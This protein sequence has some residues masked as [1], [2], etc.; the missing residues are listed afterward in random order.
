MKK[1]IL[2]ISLITLSLT[3]N[4][5]II[6]NNLLDGYKTGDKLEKSAYIE[7][8]AMIQENTWCAAY[9]KDPKA[10]TT[11]S[12]IIGKELSYPEYQEGGPSIQFGFEDGI[13]GTR[14]SVYSMTSSGKTYRQGSYYLA[15]L[16]N[17]S[18]LGTKKTSEF[19][20]LIANHV[21]GSA[22]G[23]IY[24]HRNENGKLKFTVGLGKNRTEAPNEYD[25]KKTHLLVLKVDYTNNRVEL[26]VNPSL[27][28]EEAQS[29]AMAK[30]EEGALKAGLKAIS[31]RNN[32]TYQGNIGNIRFAGRWTDITTK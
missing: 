7:P 27:K 2:I 21:G 31:I 5:Q 25:F 22:R 18:K 23:N 30:G 26:F 8:K 3:G 16:V 32:H 9:T 17:F 28:G 6:K 1:I 11:S 20:A 24:A 29:D 10:A 13:K 12:P 14:S 4:A 15:C 19:L